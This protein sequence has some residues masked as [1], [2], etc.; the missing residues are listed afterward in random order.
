MLSM[1]PTPGR[2]KTFVDEV[3]DDD[4]GGDGGGGGGGGDD[5][6]EDDDDDDDD[7]DDDVESLLCGAQANVVDEANTWK[8][9]NS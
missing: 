4:D 7:E 1:K 3:D 2:N 9:Q 6:D 5:D 8:K